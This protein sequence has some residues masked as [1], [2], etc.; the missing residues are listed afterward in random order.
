MEGEEA[1]P[2][3]SS[4]QGLAFP[5]SAVWHSEGQGPGMPRIA[6]VPL[7]D[8]VSQGQPREGMTG[9]S[10]PALNLHK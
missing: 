8:G 10:L 3:L 9:L 4:T 1:L 2:A 7:L 6:F 5:Y